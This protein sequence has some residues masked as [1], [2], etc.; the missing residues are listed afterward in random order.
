[1]DW[2]QAYR[3]YD[4]DTL[5]A[6]ANAGLLR[7]ALK[8]VEA[9]KLA[10]VERGQAGGV[11][12]AD[13]QR[14]TLD[15]R[16][17]Q[18][19]RC[20]CP[21]PGICKHILGAALWL[22][23]GGGAVEEGEADGG[24]AGTHSNPAPVEGLSG[25]EADGGGAPPAGPG[26]PLAE[27]LALAPAALF[28]AAGA[29]AVR[30]A[31]G[32]PV[33]QVDWQVQGATLVMTLPELGQTCRWVAGAGFAGMVS[34][35]PAAQCKAVHLIAIA[36]LRAQQGQPLAWPAGVQAVTAPQ[37]GEAGLSERERAFLQQVQ[38]TLQELLAGGLSHVSELTSARLLA[39]NMSARGEGLPRLAALLRNLGG[40]VELLVRRD[41]RAQER[42]ALAEMARI[43][44]LCV[45][46]SGAQGALAGGL[47]GRVRR[48]FDADATLALLPLGG[49]WWQ[50]RGGA[51]GL[52]LAFWDVQHGRLLQAALARPDGSDTS[53]NPRSAWVSQAWWPGAGTAQRLCEGT[54]TLSQPR[55]AENGRIAPGGATRAQAGPAWAAD[56]P[57]VQTLGCGDW[58]KLEAML[59]QATGLAG[60]PLDTVVLR[61]A[62]TR[63]PVLDEASQQLA[64]PLQ[65]AAGRWLAPVI[66]VGPDTQRRAEN[67]V[68]LTARRAAVHAVLVRV[69]RGAASTLLVPLAVLSENAQ[70]RLQPIALDF[71]EEAQRPT[72][73]GG[74]IL[75]LFE[76][77]QKLQPSA[78]PSLVPASLAGRLLAPVAAVL[79]EQAATGRM[80]LTPSQAQR[81]QAAQELLASVG[82]ATLAEAVQ[83]HLRAPSAQG[84]LRLSLLCEWSLELDSL[85]AGTA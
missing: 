20:D 10:W 8:D 14:V 45:A 16:G 12:S 38:A 77:R 32:T 18:Q 47:R 58:Q 76:A 36:A 55:L 79:E 33:T 40:T 81:L 41:H 74:R 31:A 19:A 25:A 62:G 63:E 1:M 22:R 73:L 3:A 70:G 26:D 59:R 54:L 72:S 50:T 48:D 24:A 39:L 30:R 83:A 84:V 4:D 37:P 60:E 75:R 49:H 66:P 85:Q 15:A 61:P 52:T 69:E 42:D 27:V 68:R 35:V 5:T 29:A 71:A 64:W 44:A 13:G 28:K 23:A 51:R 11:V 53:F 80:P 82:L 67:L 21:A 17:P 57:R 7:R 46:L 43:H 34:E 65:D 6:L 2:T 9:G 78:L 56:D